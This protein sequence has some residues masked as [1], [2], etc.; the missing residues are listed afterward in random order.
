[1]PEDL[2]VYTVRVYHGSDVVICS[3]F[4]LSAMTKFRSGFASDH[5]VVAR[6]VAFASNSLSIPCILGSMEYSMVWDEMMRQYEQQNEAAHTSASTS[7]NTTTIKA[8][9]PLRNM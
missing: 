3:T 9:C 6:F 4:D 2:S 5:I 1:M 7:A 8:M